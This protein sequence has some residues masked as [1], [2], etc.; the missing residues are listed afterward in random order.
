MRPP[1]QHLAPRPG[2]VE[3]LPAPEPVRG[4]R[5]ARRRWLALLVLLALVAAGVD[6]GYAW[7]DQQLQAPGS[8]SESVSFQVSP[9]ESSAQV[10]QALYGKG[11]IRDPR[12]FLLYLRY[13]RYRGQDVRI[14]AG[15]FTLNR[16][17]TMFQ[18]LRALGH[19]SA[20]QVVVSLPEGET[21]AQ[22]AQAAQ[23]A[24]IGTAQQYLT[25]A[26][27]VV[28]WSARFPFLQGRPSGAPDNLEGFLY[29]DTYDLDR[30]AS[31]RDLIQRQL[32]RFQQQVT[33]QM[34]AAMAQPAPGRPAETLFNVIVLASIVERE[35]V[36]SRDRALVC[37]VFYNRL[38]AGMPLQ[39]DVTV[40]YGL[41]M[42]Q[43]QLTQADLRKDTPYNTYLH[44]GLP[45]GPIS[46]PGLASI[47][48]CIQPEPSDYLFF[49]TDKGGIVHYARTFTEFQREQQQ[50]G[51]GA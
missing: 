20:A 36:T 45:A 49:F 30:G 46:N 29:P 13:L 11:L 48:A 26:Q 37:G 17:M 22:M 19:G 51:L 5:R 24:G 38:A 9:G 50:Y 33:P 2:P 21:M 28:A 34:V 27:D 41:G 8:T 44:P 47:Q 40:M 7:L 35:V 39:D 43:D 14:E 42:T 31:P 4:R 1:A 6:R 32:Q 10:A 23:R 3:F 15:H 25:A 18:V 16:G 12:V